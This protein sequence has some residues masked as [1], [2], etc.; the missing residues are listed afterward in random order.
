[1]AIGCE[2]IPSR[3]V[4]R[5]DGRLFVDGNLAANA[6]VAFHPLDPMKTQGRCPVGTTRQ[7]GSFELTT[8]SMHDGAP[9]GE[10]AVTVTWLDDSMPEDECEC[11]DV[12][13]HD[14]LLGKY[15]DPRTTTL[16]VTVLPGENQ[17]NICAESVRVGV[18]AFDGFSGDVR[19]A[20]YL[21]NR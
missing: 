14:R 12:L 18:T 6:N 8:Y 4:F 13:L 11:P 16:W 19:F 7:D 15:A 3:Q 10:Y 9:P 5:V 2:D 1:M 20:E 17:V 21:E